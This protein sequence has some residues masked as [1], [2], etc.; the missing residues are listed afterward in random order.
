MIK[1]FGFGKSVLIESQDISYD[2]NKPPTT[3]A[4]WDGYLERLK[5]EEEDDILFILLSQGEVSW[6]P[7][8]AERFAE[9][10]VRVFNQRLDNCA[11]RLD[12]SLEHT[13]GETGLVKGLLATRRSL[14]YLYQLA[15][16]SV[17]PE[18]LRKNLLESLANYAKQTQSSLENSAKSDRTGQ[19]LSTI[20]HNSILAY[21]E[22]DV[23]NTLISHPTVNSVVQS[24]VESL[25]TFGFKKRQFL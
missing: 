2:P 18:T 8:V 7:G 3:Y 17:F 12:R 21:T 23:P 10:M 4:E 20:K 22:I 19:L 1:L 5:T 24:K 11:K 9:K 16:L 25:P 15:N 6:T 14:A 13:T